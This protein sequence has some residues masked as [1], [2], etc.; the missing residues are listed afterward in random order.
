[1]KGRKVSFCSPFFNCGQTTVTGGCYVSLQR[2]VSLL[3]TTMEAVEC[4]GVDPTI[5]NSPSVV[6]VYRTHNGQR[7]TRGV[8]LKAHGE[9]LILQCAEWGQDPALLEAAMKQIRGLTKGDGEEDAVVVRREERRKKA[10]VVVDIPSDDH[11]EEEEEEVVVPLPDVSRDDDND[12]DSIWNLLGQHKDELAAQQRAFE[13]R[14][15]ARLEADRTERLREAREIVGIDSV[16][17][18]M[19]TDEGVARRKAAMDAAAAEARAAAMAEMA[20]ERERMLAELEAEMRAREASGL[21]E[22]Q[23]RLS[24]RETAL[25]DELDKKVTQVQH[26]QDRALKRRKA[27]LE[28]D[29]DA[30]L[31]RRANSLPCMEKIAASIMRK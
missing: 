20:R 2:C 13:R 26:D 24:E 16:R 14:I 12:M 23:K 22:V 9:A 1:M 17:L 15:E 10:V 25:N 18:F 11:H 27:D 28:A 3:E 19:M 31:T 30:E 29:Q 6:E 4:A 5:A 21:A 8:N 7:K